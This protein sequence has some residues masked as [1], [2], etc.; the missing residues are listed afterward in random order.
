MESKSKISFKME[1]ELKYTPVKHPEDYLN[2]PL[3]AP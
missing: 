3:F 2:W 1:S